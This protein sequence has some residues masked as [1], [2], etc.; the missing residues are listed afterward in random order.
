MSVNIYLAARFETQSDAKRLRDALAEHGIGCTSRWL[1]EEPSL[2]ATLTDERR[3]YIAAMDVFDVR[4]A[5]ALVLWNPTEKHKVGTGGCHTEVGMALAWGLPVFVVGY[6]LKDPLPLVPSNVFHFLSQVKCYAWPQHLDALAHQIRQEC[7][8]FGPT[9][10]SAE[11]QKQK[12]C[13][14]PGGLKQ[15]PACSDCGGTLV[16][17]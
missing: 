5:Q 1:E 16:V 12:A 15:L 7:P 3:R 6:D 8:D 10:D 2:D 4:R 9:W 14:H 13:K 11:E 17:A